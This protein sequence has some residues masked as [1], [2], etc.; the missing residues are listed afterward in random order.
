MTSPPSAHP[1][2]PTPHFQEVDPL[3][4][5]PIILCDIQ[6]W[7]KMPLIVF[8]WFPSW[9]WLAL[10][11]SSKVGGWP[12]QSPFKPNSFSLPVPGD[13]RF[14]WGGF[15][16]AKRP[17]LLQA[18]LRPCNGQWDDGWRAAGGGA[19]VGP[20]RQ[21]RDVRATTT[22]QFPRRTFFENGEREKSFSLSRMTKCLFDRPGYVEI[23][24][25]WTRTSVCL[26][27]KGERMWRSLRQTVRD[28]R[29][30]SKV[31]RDCV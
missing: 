1:Q 3:G 22:V 21:V 15:K 11:L 31:D 20:A 10:C 29:K 9:A 5:G 17:L 19:V 13:Q 2:T 4:R 7:Y 14:G 12:P 26:F 30:N 8:F 27:E 18:C 24:I 6:T 28:E 23:I 25:I 16:S